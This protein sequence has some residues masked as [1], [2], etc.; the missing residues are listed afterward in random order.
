MPKDGFSIDDLLNP[1]PRAYNPEQGSPRYRQSKMNSGR[2]AARLLL[3]EL[4]LS[5][6]PIDLEPVCRHFMVQIINIEKVPGE[7]RALGR[8]TGDGR[9]EIIKGLPDNLYRSTLAHEI[10]HLA[11]YHD[12]R[13]RWDSLESINESDPHEREAWDFAGELLLPGPIF[14]KEFF[15]NPDLDSLARLFAVSKE[16]LSVELVK[17]RGLL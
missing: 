5:S 3:K 17:R 15:N 7:P 1:K 2:K 16:L 4:K 6:V 12:I 10:G 11:L 9:I 8:F 14:K 13:P